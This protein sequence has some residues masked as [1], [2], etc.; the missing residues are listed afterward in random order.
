MRWSLFACRDD[1]GVDGAGI[2]V[3]VVDG[4]GG[5]VVVAVAGDVGRAGDGRR[6]E[7]ETGSGSAISHMTSRPSWRLTT[8]WRLVRRWPLF[9][10]THPTAN[11]V[12]FDYPHMSYPLSPSGRPILLHFAVSN[13]DPAIFQPSSYRGAA[14]EIW[15]FGSIID[16]HRNQF[17]GR[18]CSL[19]QYSVQQVIIAFCLILYLQVPDNHGQ[20]PQKL[21]ARG[22]LSL[23]HNHPRSRLLI[24]RFKSTFATQPP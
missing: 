24:P 2:A 5:K 7:T 1:W 4:D 9:V 3:V 13:N 20:G 12:C 8:S 6:A 16:V 17:A 15:R 23:F 22:P 10:R 18:Y 19:S 14:V 11:N 21:L